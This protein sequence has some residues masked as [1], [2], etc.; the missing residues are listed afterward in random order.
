VP[1]FMRL[2]RAG[3]VTSAEL[4]AVLVKTG[5]AVTAAL[6]GIARRPGSGRGCEIELV[7]QGMMGV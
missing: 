2:A 3:W 4:I 1:G 7:S 5:S 6:N